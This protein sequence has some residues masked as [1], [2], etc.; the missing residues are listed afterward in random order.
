MSNQ[1]DKH[2]QGFS[3][4]LLVLQALSGMTIQSYQAKISDFFAWYEK[5]SPDAGA[6]NNSLLEISRKDIE[7]YLEY[8]FYKGNGNQTRFTKLIALKKYF[9]YL[10]YE[11]VMKEDI[12]ALIPSPK[13][14][15]KFVQKFSKEDVLAFFR[16]VNVATEKGI[17]DAVILILAAFCGLR[18]SEITSLNLNDIIDDGKSL[19][20]NVIDSKHNS[21]RVVYLW[22]APSLFVRQ[23]FSVRLSQNAKAGGPFLV[24]YRKSDKVKGTSN[25]L[26]SVSVNK[27]VKKCA[28]MAN[29]RKPRVHAHM[30]RATHASDLRSIEG[31]DIP[32]IAERLGHKHISSTDR[33]FPSRGRIHRKYRSLAAYWQEFTNLWKN[34]FTAEDAENSGGGIV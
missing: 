20:I 24:S 32:A 6:N 7:A 16:V 8:C 27:L 28:D 18:V 33:Y 11:G 12:T 3:R 17:R 4:H 1:T 25:R 15:R 5:K 30:F 22:K 2:I 31:Y 23:W 9:R 13:L 21:N 26:T 14:S 10:V 29:M 19:D 34:Q